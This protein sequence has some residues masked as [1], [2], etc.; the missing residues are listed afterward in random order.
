MASTAA[1]VLVLL[2]L[3]TAEAA[4]VLD[5]GFWSVIEKE[6]YF[7]DPASWTRIKKMESRAYA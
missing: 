3:M 6:K 7:K 1:L 2:P 5:R 4:L